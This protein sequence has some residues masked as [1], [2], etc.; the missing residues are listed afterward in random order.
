MFKRSHREL[1]SGAKN[2]AFYNDFVFLLT[3]K[4]GRSEYSSFSKHSCFKEPTRIAEIGLCH[5]DSSRELEVS[6]H[7][8][9]NE[10]QDELSNSMQPKFIHLPNS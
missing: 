2:W 6:L 1:L 10:I 5:T 8:K 4:H 9:R 7:Y 3:V